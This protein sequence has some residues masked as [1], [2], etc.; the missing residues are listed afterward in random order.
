MRVGGDAIGLKRCA[1]RARGTEAA[2]PAAG[3]VAGGECEPLPRLRRPEVRPSDDISPALSVYDGPSKDGG[4]M[5]AP[6][7][8]VYGR[9]GGLNGAAMGVGAAGGE[10]D[11]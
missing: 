1:E 11:E 7:I 8:G 3:N 4:E 2:V 10:D 5:P 9:V 6:S